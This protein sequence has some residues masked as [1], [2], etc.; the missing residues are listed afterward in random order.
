[1][2]SART[3]LLAMTGYGQEADRQRTREAGF[4]GHLVKPVDFADLKRMLAE[5]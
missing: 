5:T 3:R 4:S 2:K 1:M